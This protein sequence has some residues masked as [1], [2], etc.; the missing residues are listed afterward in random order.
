MTATGALE[1]L[2]AIHTGKLVKLSEQQLLDCV[3]LNSTGCEGGFPCA[4]FAYLIDNGGQVPYDVYP[5]K[6]VQQLQ[7][8]HVI[9]CLAS[10]FPL[11]N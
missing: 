5:Y 1:G 4:C 11:L 7:Y 10:R 3:D 9:V 6:G 8:K 2:N